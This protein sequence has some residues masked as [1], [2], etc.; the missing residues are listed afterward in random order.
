MSKTSAIRVKSSERQAR[1]LALRA[2]GA[3]FQQIGDQLGITRQSA[4]EHVT[5]GIARHVADA[6]TA[7]SELVVL[8]TLRLDTLQ[9]AVWR[10]A[11]SGDLRAVDR[12]LRIM[13]RRA[14]L[15]GLDAATDPT[16]GSI[17]VEVA[18]PLPDPAAQPEPLVVEG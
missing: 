12:V 18:W 7:A 1:A 2:A 9:S 3:T 5:R 14:R 10:A 11:V 8:E 15:L 4:H 16:V 6:D 17:T 13:E